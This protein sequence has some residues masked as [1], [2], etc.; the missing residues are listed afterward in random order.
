MKEQKSQ[1]WIWMQHNKLRKAKFDPHDHCFTMYNEN[2]ELLLQRKR[3]PLDEM[4]TIEQSLQ[5]KGAKR[6][7][8]QTQPFIYIS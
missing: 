8:K 3:I 1:I 5:K 6:I 2:D 4:K 7:D